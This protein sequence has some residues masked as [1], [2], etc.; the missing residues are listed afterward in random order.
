VGMS[1]LVD[2]EQERTGPFGSPAED[3]RELP[4]NLTAAAIL[5]PQGLDP[6]GIGEPRL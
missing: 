2:R 3:L 4:V 5:V 6:H 1:G